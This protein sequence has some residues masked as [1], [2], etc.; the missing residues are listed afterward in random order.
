M[1]LAAAANA[2]VNDSFVS[3]GFTCFDSAPNRVSYRRGDVVIRFEYYPEDAVPRPLNVA[4][5]LM[6]S[7]GALHGIGAWELILDEPTAPRYST[8]RFKDQ[9]ELRETLR[10]VYRDVVE[11]SLSDYIADPSKLEQVVSASEQRRAAEYDASEAQRLVDA[12]RRA[13]DAGRYQDALDNYA[14]TGMDLGPLDRKRRDIASRR[15]RSL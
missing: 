4:I 8:W 12:A 7:D 6:A 3:A 9:A 1:D 15:V 5:G 2:E 11:S 14:L 10:R 13:F